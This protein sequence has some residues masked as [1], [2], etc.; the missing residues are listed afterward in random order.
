MS[1]G[2]TATTAPTPSA[3]P[4][5]PASSLP[6]GARERLVQAAARLFST[7]GVH[8]GVDAVCREAGVSK[9][10][11]YQLFTS[12][13][14]LVAASL[15]AQLPARA[16]ELLPPDEVRDPRARILHVFERQEAL[17]PGND[18][19]GCPFLS[20]AV[21]VKTSEHPAAA[22]VRD[23][24]AGLASFFAHEAARAGVADAELLARQLMV[25]FDGASSASVVSARP[26]EGLGVL[27]ARMLLEAAGSERP[28]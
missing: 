9:R 25:V 13:E 22:V 28:Q 18:F 2:V 19:H 17:E 15:V 11:M 14:E 8:V 12:K 21:E 6:G 3:S 27:T 4:A 10:S 23:Q 16:A 1:S 20:A 5:P 24:K 7:Q 26:L